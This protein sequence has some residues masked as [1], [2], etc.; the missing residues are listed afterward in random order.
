MKGKRM[1]LIAAALVSLPLTA[2]AF[3]YTY[4]EGGFFTHDDEHDDDSGFRIAGSAGLLKSAA[5]FGEFQDTGDDFNQ[6]SVGGLFHASLLPMLDLTL[7]GSVERVDAGRREDT[8][9]GLRGGV[10]WTVLPLL[11]LDPEVR[12]V[13]VFDDGETSVRL[14]ALFRVLPHLDVQGAAQAGDD[15]RLEIGARFSF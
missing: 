9:F 5:L 15:D 11:E 4:V 1:A 10:R 2:S 14:G 3:D 8:G 7:G 13:D 12:F 6:L